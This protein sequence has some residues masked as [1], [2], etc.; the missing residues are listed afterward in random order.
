M[1]RES[2]LE[3][4]RRYALMACNIEYLCVLREKSKDDVAAYIGMGRTTFYARL[5][6]PE[7]FTLKELDDMA[8]YLNC[9]VEDITY[10]KLTVPEE[11]K[12][13]RRGRS[14]VCATA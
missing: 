8:R 10:G 4:R 9:T 14:P 2:V 11:V 7:Q 1:A 12:E 13:R 6:R 3:A 5:K